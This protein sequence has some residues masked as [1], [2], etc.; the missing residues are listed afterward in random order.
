MNINKQKQN[1]KD[2]VAEYKS[3]GALRGVDFSSTSTQINALLNSPLY[4]ADS[5]VGERISQKVSD[6]FYDMRCQLPPKSIMRGMTPIANQFSINGRSER[7]TLKLRGFT[8]FQKNFKGVKVADGGYTFVVL[9]NSPG[10]VLLG[11]RATGGHTAISRGAPVF[12]AGEIFF[13]KGQ[14]KGWNNDSGHYQTDQA[15][16]TQVRHLLPHGLFTPI[17]L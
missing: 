1:L 2:T 12:F 7:W 11:K 13:D 17:Q 8:Y 3:L 4:G 9:T 15:L 16:Y 10:E 5:A 14:L 6:L